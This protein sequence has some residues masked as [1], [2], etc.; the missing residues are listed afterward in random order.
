MTTFAYPNGK[1]RS[2]YNSDTRDIV[3][4]VGFKLAVT[5]NWGI[6]TINTDRFQLNR[7][8]PWDKEPSKYHLRLIRNALGI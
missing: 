7:F 5:T 6:S 8:S 4:S 2:D 1:Q 3:E